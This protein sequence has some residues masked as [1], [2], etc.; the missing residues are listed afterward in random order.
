MSARGREYWAPRAI[1]EP[2]KAQYVPRLE[3]HAAEMRA[4]NHGNVAK[5][6]AQLQIWSSGKRKLPPPERRTEIA[7]LGWHAR[8]DLSGSGA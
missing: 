2:R 3:K 5:R 4:R 6:E 8:F 1:D 7:R